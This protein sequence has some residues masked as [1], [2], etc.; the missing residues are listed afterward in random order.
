MARA[1]GE[2]APLILVGAVTYVSYTPNP[3][4][5]GY[6]VLPIQIYQWA[7]RPQVEFQAIAASAIIV[8]LALLFLLNILAVVIRIRL[9]RHLQW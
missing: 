6:T 5:G 3:F 4:S 7:Q 9:S 8:I 2:T 1:I